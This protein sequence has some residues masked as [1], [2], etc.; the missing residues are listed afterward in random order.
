LWDVFG[1]EDVMKKQQF[2]D[3]QGKL[4]K[5]ETFDLDIPACLTTDSSKIYLNRPKAYSIT[6]SNIVPPQVSLKMTRM[7]KSQRRQLKHLLRLQRNVKRLGKHGTKQTTFHFPCKGGIT[8]VANLMVPAL[9]EKDR[10]KHAPPI[11]LTLKYKRTIRDVFDTWFKH[12][13][14]G[15]IESDRY[16]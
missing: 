4:S 15:V 6:F 8:L 13:L 12:S 10:R 3:L 5:A 14:D 9:S 11:T 7:R 2:I 16:A 1:E